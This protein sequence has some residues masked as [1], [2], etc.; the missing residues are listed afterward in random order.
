MA[1]LSEIGRQ[2]NGWNPP[3]FVVLEDQR[4]G[5]IRVATG[6]L[7][8]PPVLFRDSFEPGYLSQPGGSGTLIQ[9]RTS[10]GYTIRVDHH[11]VTIQDPYSFNAVQHWGDPHENLNGKHIKDWGGVAGW[12]GA[13]RTT[14]IDGGAKITMESMGPTGVVLFT[15]IYDG[16]QNV[17]IDNAANT[18]IHHGTDLADTLA[19]ETSQYDGETA[20]FTTNA[21]TAVALYDHVYNEDASFTVVASSR[22]LGST[23]G[24]A[25]PNQVNDYF[26]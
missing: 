2:I 9:F 15:S 7:E 18:I 17:R 25:N 24:C 23:G 26:P 14:L 16:E 6:N 19:L 20:R 13:R 3:P 11:T 5:A 8:C 12:D 10:S 21:L 4:P 22:P 1:Q